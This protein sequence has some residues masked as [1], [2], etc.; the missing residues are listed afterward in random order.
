MVAREVY[1]A[2]WRATSTRHV[3]HG[4]SVGGRHARRRRRPPPVAT[5]CEH[6]CQRRRHPLRC[7]RWH[8]VVPADRVMEAR[9]R[10]CRWLRPATPL[11]VS[12]A[13]AAGPSDVPLLLLGV[14]PR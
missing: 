10:A 2:W 6:R 14:A 1:L 4:E 8:A 5:A 11:D 7:T 9:F 12:T 13:A 3:A